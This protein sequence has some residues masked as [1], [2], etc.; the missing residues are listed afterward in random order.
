MVIL[1][2]R[3]TFN[4]YVLCVLLGF[5]TSLLVDKEQLPPKDSTHK[6][7]MGLKFTTNKIFFF[8]REEFF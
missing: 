2:A 7:Y 3:D 4:H 5:I 1:Q 8:L 6:S